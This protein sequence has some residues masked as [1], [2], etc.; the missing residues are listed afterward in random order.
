MSVIENSL[1]SHGDLRLETSHTGQIVLLALTGSVLLAAGMIY[2]DTDIGFG[3]RDAAEMTFRFSV[4]LFV[5]G[6]VVEPLARLFPAAPMRAIG[7]ER[8]SLILAFAMTSVISLLCVLV[9]PYLGIDRMTAPTVFYTGLT[10]AILIVM[11]FSAHPAT[12]RLLGAP[13][14]RTMQRIATSYFW[15][16]FV[17]IGIDHIVG[18][19][20]PNSWYGLS[21]LLLTGTLLIRFV[22]AFA[23]RMR[24]LPSATIGG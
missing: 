11:L 19:H 7:R 15:L 14:W 20:R 12:I 4:L 18:P 9:P 10:A 23:V 16:V 5:A 6:M 8:G 2:R 3:W 22:D 24:R 17:L 21:L 1:P 13:A